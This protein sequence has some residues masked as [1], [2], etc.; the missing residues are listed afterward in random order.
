MCVQYVRRN[1]LERFEVCE[2]FLGFCTVLEVN[3]EAITS[4]IVGLVTT[5][6]VHIAKT[7]D[8]LGCWTHV[9]STICY[10]CRKQRP[11]NISFKGAVTCLLTKRQ[12]GLILGN[13]VRHGDH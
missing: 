7:N 8:K 4:A 11:C 6:K 12:F 10:F 9:G 3:A 13:F 2:E 5:W 1:S